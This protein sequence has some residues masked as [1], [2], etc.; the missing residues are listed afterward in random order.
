MHV[1]A[2]LLAATVAGL[3]AA[4]PAAALAGTGDGVEVSGL[5]W[6]DL[7]GDGTRDDGEPGRADVQVTLRTSAT[8][9]DAT[10]TAPDGS[11]TFAKVQ[12]GTYTLVIEPP[13]DHDITGGTLPGLDPD[14]G[15]AEISVGTEPV[16]DAGTVGLGSPVTSGADVAATVTLDR[17]GSSAD[18]YR[19]VVTA[20]NLGPE[21]ADGPVDLRIVLSADH[22]TVDAAGEGWSCDRS[23]AIVLCEAATG[24]PAATSLPDVTLTTRPVG[25]VGARV[26]VTGTVRLEGAFDAAPLNDEDSA[27]AS[28]GGDLAA[29]DLDG[30]GT[31]DLT[32]AG[33]STSGVLVAGLLALVLGAVAVRTSGRT[34][35]SAHSTHSTPRTPQTPRP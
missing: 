10:T 35:H 34:T 21:D 31:G 33:A 3:L 27:T 28:I 6:L 12:P 30:D 14:S 9:V 5:V 23:A 22:E 17:A 20:H 4:A 26:S 18:R 11:W 24:I 19:W 29:A 8:I 32:N 25:D 15:E 1:R 7:D 2:A 13:L 16:T